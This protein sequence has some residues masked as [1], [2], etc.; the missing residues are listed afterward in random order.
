MGDS[1]TP[2]KLLLYFACIVVSNQHRSKGRGG[3]A[4]ENDLPWSSVKMIIRIQESGELILI[5]CVDVL[6]LK[7][8]S[9]VCMSQRAA[10]GI[11]I[12]VRLTSVHIFMANK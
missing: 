4:E 1:K 10:G 11:S 5:H 2:V 12:L 6:L 9:H 3:V 8:V 7:L